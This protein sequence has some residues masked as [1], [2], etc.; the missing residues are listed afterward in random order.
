MGTYL[1]LKKVFNFKIKNL[2]EKN[3]L[4]Q[5]KKNNIQLICLAGF[6]KIL[7]KILSINLKGKY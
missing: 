5:L 4:I 6:M 2:A 1:K 7:T 3:I